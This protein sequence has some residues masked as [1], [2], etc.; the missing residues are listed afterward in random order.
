VVRLFPF[1]S[2]Y[3]WG[4]IWKKGTNKWIEEW[5]LEDKENW[6]ALIEWNPI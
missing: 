2:I 5:K 3:W 1:V 4:G 6:V